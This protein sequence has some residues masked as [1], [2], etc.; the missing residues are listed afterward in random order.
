MGGSSSAKP[1]TVGNA[2]DSD[3]QKIQDL[4]H[5]SDIVSE[6][7]VRLGQGV[8]QSAIDSGYN[9]ADTSIGL[10]QDLTR[11]SGT[12]GQKLVSAIMRSTPELRKADLPRLQDIAKRESEINELNSNAL[13]Q[14]VNPD[15]A[16]ARAEVSKQIADDLGGGVSPELSNLWLKQGLADVIA[17]GARTDSGFARAALAD[18]TRSDYIAERE[19]LQ[20]RAKGLVDSNPK[21]T[22]GIDPGS[23]AQVD[24]ATRGEN[25][26]NRE[27]WRQAVLSALG[28]HVNNT[29]AG[30]QAQ[31]ENVTGSMANQANTV[32]Q[33]MSN[34]AD[35]VTNAGQT[36]VQNYLN[37]QQQ[38]VQAEAQVRAQNAQAANAASAASS[39]NNAALTSSLIGGGAAIGGAVILAF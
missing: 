23:L 10:G 18:K 11:D 2:P 26:D 28:N 20:E 31:V 8:N 36:A 21:P 24:A 7:G 27:Q 39:S 19:R 34:D 22:A 32:N 1:A 38:K 6:G 16:R 9:V 15:V 14:E 33:A 25:T 35:L 3:W 12:L 37:A 30:K 4:L 29:I 17:T 5:A 13:E